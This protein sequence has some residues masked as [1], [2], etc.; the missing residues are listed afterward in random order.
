MLE[1]YEY[2]AFDK[3]ELKK[4]IKNLNSANNMHTYFNFKQ[5]KELLF[6]KERF[7]MSIIGKD[8]ILLLGPLGSGK[9]TTLHYLCG[10]KMI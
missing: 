2:K 3:N 6:S 1:V 9:S 8:M 5:F 10:S 7:A 4:I